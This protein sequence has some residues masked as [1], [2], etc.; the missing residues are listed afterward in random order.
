MTPPLS[1]THATLDTPP[2]QAPEISPALARDV[3]AFPNGLPGFEACHS[4]VLM[5]AEALSPVQCLKAVNGPPASFLVIDPRR[6]LADYR[7]ELSAADRHR[8]AASEGDTLLWL[9]LLTIEMDGTIS[10]NLRAPV[11]INPKHMIGHQVVP[12][13]C[14][15]PIRYVIA[16]GE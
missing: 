3:V 5:Q 13:Q 10:A 9:V 2:P 6:V 1:R 12:H 8:L 14:V 16:T 11:V 15:Y 7:C 4:F